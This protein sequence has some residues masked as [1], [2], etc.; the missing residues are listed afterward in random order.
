MIPEERLSTSPVVSAFQGAPFGATLLD[1]YEHGGVALND[2]S[3]GMVAKLWKIGYNFE[4][5]EVYVSAPGVPPTVLFTRSGITELSLA[6]DQ[7]MNPFVAFVQDGVSKFWWYDPLLPGMA[8]EEALIATAITPRC[9]L[10][11]KRRT[12]A[13]NSDVILAYMR[14]GSLYYRQQRD[15]F[16]TER[17]LHAD[18]GGRLQAIGMNSGLRL[19]FKVLDATHESLVSEPPVLADIVFD[20]CQQSGIDPVNIDVKDLYNDRV[21]GLKVAIAEGLDKPIDQLREVFF[22]DKAERDRA[23]RWPKR[24]RPVVARI[25]YEHLVQGNPVALKIKVRDESKLPREIHINHLDP[26]GGYAKNKQTAQRRSNLV[27]AKGKK[28]ITTGVVLEADQAAT[29]VMTRLKVAW[30]ELLDYEF[31][32]TLRYTELVPGEDVIE[33]E[34]SRGDWHRM[35][36]EERNDE[37][38]H[39]EWKGV[40]DAGLRTY[41]PTFAGNSLPPPTSTTPGLVGETRLELL[42][43]PVQRDEDD[44]LGVYV[45]AAGESAGWTGYQLIGSRDGGSSFVEVF[46]STDAAT[47]GETLTDLEEEAGYEYQS[48]QTLDVVVNYPLASISYDQLLGNQNRFVVGDMVAQF[49]TAVLQGMV[50]ARYHYRL[51][52]LILSRYHTPPAF[53]PEGTRFVLLDA[54]VRFVR[55]Q[56]WAVGQDLAYK[57]VSLGATEDE[58]TTTLYLFDEPASQTEWPVHDVE[59][60]RDVSDNVTVTWSGSARLGVDTAPYHSKYFNGYRVKFDDGHTIDTA[61]TSV[62]YSAAPVGVGVQVCAMNTITGEGPYSDLLLT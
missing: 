43:I 28:T 60:D 35:R 11:D 48:D 1:D 8:F 38:S 22:F 30:N 6:F 56:Q 10:D 20:L 15:R 2:P 12:Q 13:S 44:E 3:E 53:W 14:S 37:G 33:V 40:Q 34:D 47:L 51:S 49:Q 54:A 32:T 42:N 26:A 31:S 59:A 62:V 23:I 36:L 52:G 5:S 58:T 57:P 4:T 50:G 7:N 9:T 18:L 29:A 39:I 41:G 61:G 27:R 16:L 19:Q 25:P 21:H 24:G 17:L 55:L 45:A 46:T